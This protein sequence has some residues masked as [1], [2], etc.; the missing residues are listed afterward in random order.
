MPRKRT[1]IAAA[2][3][4]SNKRVRISNDATIIGQQTSE[5]AYPSGRP[6]RTSVSD[7]PPVYNSNR[8]RIPAAVTAK[9]AETSKSPRPVG[10][11]K[12]KSTLA[13]I[14]KKRGRPARAVAHSHSPNIAQ[15]SPS[16]RGRP[17][18]TSSSSSPSVASDTPIKRK[19]G[20]PRSSLTATEEASA[21]EGTPKKG[22]R[23]KK[24]PATKFTRNKSHT[25]PAGAEAAMNT[26][27]PQGRR[28]RPAK[29]AVESPKDEELNTEDSAEDDTEENVYEDENNRQYWLM[30]AEPES[31][32]ENGKDVKFSIDDLMNATEPEGWDGVRN[33]AVPGI[34]GIM[35]IVGEHSVDESAFN[36]EHP[37]YDKKSTREN[38][39]WDLVHV[40]FRRKFSELVRLKE[41]Q[42]YAKPG[43]VLEE[44]Q[45]LRQTRLSVSKVS[46]KEW[47][48]IMELAGEE[49]DSLE[50]SGG[51]V[52]AEDVQNGEALELNANGREIL[53]PNIK[54]VEDPDEVGAVEDEG[55]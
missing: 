31:R 46:V 48:F 7:D 50:E 15:N 12:G 20:R 25:G 19:R 2:A 18:K 39:R 44:M 36:P 3:S 24:A 52:S 45:V 16:K 14:M 6:K 29:V 55:K 17:K 42:K 8:R 28:G 34:A 41:L 40:R 4:S 1:A 47:K 43:G 30:K 51:E 11:P 23:P 26:K 49:D 38:P 22:G 35:E 9:A 21:V 13:P 10:R 33:P 53:I 37:Y 32:I 54:N 27:P 5:T